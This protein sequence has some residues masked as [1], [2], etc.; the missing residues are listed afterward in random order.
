MVGAE[1]ALRQGSFPLVDDLDGRGPLVRI[2]PDDPSH[3]LI[4]LPGSDKDVGGRAALLRAGHT[5]L[6]PLRAA[7]TSG[8]H[9]K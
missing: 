7:V 8:A 3:L 4:S 6:E 5:P 9:A 1:P 2:H